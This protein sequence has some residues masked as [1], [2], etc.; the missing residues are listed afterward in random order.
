MK[1]LTAFH[2]RP[3][4]TVVF[5]AKPVAGWVFTIRSDREGSRRS[6]NRPAE[7][8]GIQG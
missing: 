2:A 4:T 6:H 7:P 3:G 8:T 5:G 1:L